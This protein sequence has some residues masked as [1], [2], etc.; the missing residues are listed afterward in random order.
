MNRPL[1]ILKSRFGYD[2]FRLEQESIIQNILEKKDT[3]ALM[4]TGGGKS[5][6]YQIPALIFEGLTIVISPLI[7]LMKDQVDALKLNGIEAAYL[8]SSLSER[9]QSEIMA[10]VKQNQLKLL[11]LAP[12]RFFGKEQQF[13]SFLKSVHLSLFAIDEAHCI[14]QWGH[15]FRP[16]Y[17]MLQKLREEFHEIPIVA[18]TAT[19]DH[20]TRKDILEKLRLRNPQTFISSFNRANI[21]YYIEPKRN[22]FERLVNY[23]RSRPEESGV[24]YALSRKSVESLASNLQ[25]EGFSARPYH[26]GLERNLKEENQE[27]FIKDKVKIIVATIAFG[28]GIDKSNVRYVVHM[29]IPKNIEGYY[30]ETGRAGRDGLK[31]EAI[32]FYS[33]GDVLKLRKFAE[34]ENNPQQSKIML[35]KLSKMA[36]LCELRAC[37]RKYLLNYFGEEFPDHCGSC[38]ICLSNYEKEDGTILAQKALSA[39]TRLNESYGINYVVDFLRGSKSE[40]MRP[41]HMELKTYGIGAQLPKEHWIRTIKDLISLGYLRQTG[42][43]YP[44]VK[45]TEKSVK[46]LRGEEKVFLVKNVTRLTVEENVVEYEKELFAKL[47]E[48]RTRLAEEENVPAY[49][50]FSDATLTELST[51]LPQDFMELKQISGFGEIKIGKYGGI[52]LDIVKKYCKEKSLPSRIANKSSKRNRKSPPSRSNG[53]DTKLE[54]LKLL[55]AGKSID[56]IA[57]IRNFVRGTIEGHLAHF[58]QEGNLE[59]TEVVSKEKIPAIEAAVKIHGPYMLRT[60]KDELG[61]EFSYGEIKCVVSYLSRK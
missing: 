59:L 35:T 1:E 4:P 7:S 28:M 50:I 29:D 39:V 53:P 57:T 26:A 24:I 42:D 48:A 23:L 47:R 33:P 5:L 18:L 54:T 49:I 43:T 56:E 13:I 45:L 25:E 16:E 30:Q 17:L 44:V 60:L 27:L 15:D 6:C 21:H 34:V 37:R 3:F 51:Y 38:D 31:S 12:E 9:E 46:V 8:N 52:F 55:R 40:R 11:Y 22:S 36:E 32:L 2:G 14:S 61:E 19:A 41:E 58:I 10:K 20:I